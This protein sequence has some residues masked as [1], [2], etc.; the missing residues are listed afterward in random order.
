MLKSGLGG[1][2]YSIL[3]GTPFADFWKGNG[4]KW[5]TWPTTAPF[6]P[7]FVAMLFFIKM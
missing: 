5:G 1:T 7:M 2:W 4:P 3:F 6:R